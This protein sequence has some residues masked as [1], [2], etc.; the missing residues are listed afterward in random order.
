MNKC[1][2]GGGG[3]GGV[4]GVCTYYSVLRYSEI[5]YINCRET[6]CIYSICYLM[7]FRLCT[8]AV[9]AISNN[10]IGEQ[11]TNDKCQEHYTVDLQE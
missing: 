1:G 6:C 9:R 11:M 4:S 3:G 5:K 7:Y 2:G 10:V 8:S